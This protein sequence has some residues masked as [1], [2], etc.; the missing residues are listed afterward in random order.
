M[1]KMA[2]ELHVLVKKMSRLPETHIPMF[3]HRKMLRMS[4][5]LTLMM[6]I[7]VISMPPM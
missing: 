6:I 5:E 1:L 2:M 7:M 3:L 4:M